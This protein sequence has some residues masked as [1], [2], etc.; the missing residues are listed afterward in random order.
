MTIEL[1]FS[2]QLDQL[3]DRFSDVVTD[4]VRSK[5]SILDPSVV[6][7]P[8]A[9]LAKWLQLLLAE[10]NSIIMNVE[11][12]YLEAGLWGMLAALDPGENKPE[13]M[14]IDQL[15]ILLLHILQNL[16][17]SDADFLPITHYLFGED[18]AERPDDA[19]RLWQLS[20]KIA[21]LFKEYEF[22]RT[23]MIR[24]W[25]A[26]TTQTEGMERCQQ[27]LYAQLKILRDELAS[28]TEKQLLSTMEYADLVLADSR[29]AAD[30][31]SVHFFGLS[32]ISNFHLTLIGRLQ[33]YY[34]IHIYT[35]NPS[36]EFW[37]DIKT[38]REK[39]W[40]RRK[41]VKI[42]AIQTSE[43]EQ[44]EL[45]QQ[46]DN[47]LLAAWG[48]PGRE[49]VR[50]LCQL[51]DYDFN[52]CF[53]TAKQAG[54]ILQRIQNDILTL[55]SSEQEAKRLDQDRSLQIVACP[56]IYREVETVY[57]SIL[58]NL[59]QD[60]RLQ[61]TDIAILVPD[62][63][64]YKPVF[65][66]V[67]NRRPRQLAYNL[68]DSH[69]DIES[70]YGKAVLAILKLASG[71]FSRNEVFDLILNPC[72]MRRWKMGPDE[73]QT[74][75]NWT[76]ELN[77]FHTF[78]SESKVARGYPASGN[79]TWKQGLERLRLSRIMAAPNVSDPA[80]FR[81][82][83]ERVPFSDVNTGDVDLV[84]KFCM[85]IESLHYAVSRLN[86]RGI[87]GE[88]WK[89]RL[90][91]T[92]DQLIEIP[93]D[94]KGEAVVRQALLK[95]FDNLELYDRLQEGASPSALD[96]DLIR[97]FVRANL[98][99]ISG[100]HG[101]YLTGGVTISALQ[102]MRPIPFDIVYVLGMEE[103]Y[104]PGKADRSSLDLRLS[105]RRIGDISL[106]E[107]NCYLFL[108][109]LLSVRQKLYISYV[110]RDL[111]KDRLQQPCSVITQLKRYVELEILSDGQPFR[112]SEVPL[113]G[114][115]DRYLDPDAIN[116]WSDVLVNDSLTDRV[117]YYRT[118]RL[119]EA[120]KH[121]ASRDDLARVARFDPDLSFDIMAPDAEDR[122]VEKITSRQLTKFL[123]HPVRLK[124][125]RH[126]GL[127][128]EEETI[129][130]VVLREDEPFFSEFPLDYRLKMDPI[131]LW[132]D[133]NFS[134]MDADTAEPD[135]ETFYHQV[136]DTCRRKS[137]TPEGAFAD[138]D[139]DAILGHV[140]Q[141]VETL[142]PVLEQMQSAKQLLRAVSIGDPVE[143]PISSDNRIGLKRFN[144]LSLMVDTLNSASETVTQAVELHG[145]L[146]WV[147]QDDA[148][149]WHALV[150]TGSAK[151][152]R[153]PDKYVLE[154]G[155][156]Y[157]ICLAGDESCRWIE[158]SGLT[159]HIVY[160]EIAKEWTYRFDRETAEAYLV[161]LVSNVL[162]QSTAAWLPFATVT[163]RSIRP[164]KMPEDEVNDAIRMQFAAE[165]EDAFAEEEDYL[166][167]IA[168]PTIPADAFD[169]VRRRFKMYFDHTRSEHVLH[170][171]G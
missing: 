35:M 168:K 59:A 146:P 23:D 66:S 33:D 98:G 157:L 87:N 73:V 134:E 133:A 116:A 56:G 50:L 152:T 27:R 125:Q 97:E 161:E 92:C 124:I 32:Q 37:E 154:P 16:D 90:F 9:N 6:I 112:V 137:Q 84:E 25:A 31:Q 99:S 162:N 63:S 77:I 166:I 34:T 153:E 19:A 10:K 115:S 91:Q 54:G 67:F 42:L 68:V 7:V 79:F 8:N 60:D 64:A 103:G 147:W 41:K 138:I 122:Q 104:F 28:R 39:R 160:R 58:F 126:L 21:H 171:C 2:N 110:S 93:Q 72:F 145:Q 131:K 118:H 86:S 107:R 62:I 101:N 40:I 135:P 113:A 96:V 69:A 128:D 71:R 139:R 132:M 158:S 3:A 167:R 108:E 15:K 61:L 82:Y 111:Q 17:R 14:D 105:R 163:T 156:F 120:F 143:E 44:G 117:A 47:A 65:D 48:K 12:Q 129:E 89:Q 18:G 151:N 5:E 100:G 20:E 83:Q 88:Q 169:R 74:W 43:Q 75:V 106:P 109:M 4:E 114:F 149:A 81:H 46:A 130:D 53:T 95:A 119:W 51:T 141:I 30:P 144:P 148:D 45:F 70:I 165:L 36:Q 142:K 55:S 85:V 49:S 24:K 170:T 121:R 140:R 127:Y 52:A 94:F 78:D 22:H 102:P 26:P 29:K 13:M 57:N 1:Y 155:L 123:E 80:G 136:Y 11:F 150:L 164:H 38:P 76:R 159:L